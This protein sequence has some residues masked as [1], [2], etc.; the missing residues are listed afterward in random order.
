MLRKNELL[1][2]SILDPLCLPIL[3]PLC[4]PILDP[5]CLP[6]HAMTLFTDRF[7]TALARFAEIS[8]RRWA[9]GRRRRFWCGTWRGGAPSG[10]D[11]LCSLRRNEMFLV[12]DFPRTMTWKRR[13]GAKTLGRRAMAREV[14]KKRCLDCS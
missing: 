5:L 1:Y 7:E 10:Q 6:T 2:N 9:L 8:Q 14:S 3:D 4:L 13:P 11:K 12:V